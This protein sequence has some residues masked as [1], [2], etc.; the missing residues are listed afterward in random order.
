[1]RANESV[2]FHCGDCQIVIDLCVDHERETEVVEG[3]PVTDFGEPTCCP[4]CG[5]GE[6]SPTHDRAIHVAVGPER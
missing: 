5:A 1:M 2:R 6:L 3:P 4:F